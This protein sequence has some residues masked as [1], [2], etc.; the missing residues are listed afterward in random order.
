MA[1]G[2][3]A[4]RQH[5]LQVP[6][7]HGHRPGLHHTDSLERGRGSDDGYAEVEFNKCFTSFSLSFYD[8]LI[9]D[10][11]SL[12]DARNCLLPMFLFN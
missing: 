2:P 4:G 11:L 7:V 10:I 3:Q 8:A 9:V 1:G 5:E 12:F 6:P